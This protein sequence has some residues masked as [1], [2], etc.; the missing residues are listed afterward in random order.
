MKCR[1]DDLS[2][3]SLS[4]RG[5][6]LIELVAVVCVVATLMAVSVSYYTKIMR[7]ARQA[8]F[9]TLSSRFTSV[10]AMAHV[11]WITGNKPQYLE[12]DSARLLMNRQGWPIGATAPYIG[13]DLDA[14]QQLWEALFQ[15]PGE[16]ARAV[17]GQKLEQEPPT[18]YWTSRPQ[19]GVCRYHMAV[20][21]GLEDGFANESYYFDYFSVD[22]RVKNNLK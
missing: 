21:D 14:C 2:P 19:R 5:F 18:R 22:G 12:L 6:T 10:V 9:E 15:N 3:L 8:G 7:D 13:K 1:L 11:H 20:P 17:A 4:Q 16:L